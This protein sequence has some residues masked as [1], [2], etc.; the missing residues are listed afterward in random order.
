MNSSNFWLRG[1]FL[2]VILFSFVYLYY[3]SVHL[4]V[5]Q[6]YMHARQWMNENRVLYPP[7]SVSA[8]SYYEQIRLLEE[9]CVDNT[10]LFYQAPILETIP[11]DCIRQSP[12]SYSRKSDGVWFSL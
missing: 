3:P 9:P 8:E 10:R 2:A 4:R 7:G 12:S 5:H 6:Q 11:P 1:L